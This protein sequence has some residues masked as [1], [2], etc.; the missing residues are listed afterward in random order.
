M[1]RVART[2]WNKSFEPAC[3]DGAYKWCSREP[4]SIERDAAGNPLK[5]TGIHLD[6]DSRRRAEQLLLTQR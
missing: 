5:V 3:V 2:S 4:E 1:H 6:I